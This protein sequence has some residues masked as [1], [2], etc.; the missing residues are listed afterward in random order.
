M[1]AGKLSL[2]FLLRRIFNTRS[3]ANKW[4]NIGWYFT[5][6]LVFPLWFVL[7]YTW[8]GLSQHNIISTQFTNAYVIPIDSILTLV[9]DLCILAL[10]VAMVNQLQ[11][12]WLKKISIMAIFALGSV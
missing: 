12:S 11:L 8:T 3:Q 6:F 7:V 5:F 4:F 9:T 10:P 1:V 2:L